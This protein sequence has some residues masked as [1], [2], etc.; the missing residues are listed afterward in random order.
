MRSVSSMSDVSHS[1]SS[2]T[3]NFARCLRGMFVV[4]MILI[5]LVTDL[6]GQ[7]VV[8][9]LVSLGL[10]AAFTIPSRL[11]SVIR[12]ELVY[13][14]VRHPLKSEN[15]K[16]LGQFLLRAATYSAAMACLLLAI[17]RAI[18]PH[19]EYVAALLIFGWIPAGLLLL[20]Q[21]VPAKDVSRSLNLLH[22]F[23]AIFLGLQLF[24][25]YV[26]S[27]YSE[28]I[29]IQ[30]PFRGEWVVLQGGRSSLINHHFFLP[31][32]RHALD[33]LAVKN[34]MHRHGDPQL[35]E[36][37]ACYDQL[38][39]SPVSG[40]VVRVTNDR[41]DQAI[42]TSDPEFPVGN[43][44]VIDMGNDRYVLLAHLKQG[45]VAAAEGDAV[46]A[47]DLIGRC[48]NSGNTSEPHLHL[49]IQNRADFYS[50]DLVAYPIGFENITHIRGGTFSSS[51]WGELRRNDRIITL[52]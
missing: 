6:F 51:Q 32:Q 16:Y 44:A 37:Y 24:R 26:V 28:P 21:L 1:T 43:H 49:Q 23:A 27:S 4:T 31:S 42:G 3:N 13:N 10:T 40:T 7:A 14:F 5:G 17:P 30:P 35:L 34:G 33:L 29:M 18:M 41:P 46:N 38:L 19:D 11:W 8:L 45:S 48:G 50:D 9:L 47:G 15:R 25:V 36:S 2:H 39:F 12:R 52:P 20:M 22:A